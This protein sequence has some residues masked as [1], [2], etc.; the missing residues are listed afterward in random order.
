MYIVWNYHLDKPTEFDGIVLF[1]S[2]DDALQAMQDNGIDYIGT[3]LAGDCYIIEN[4]ENIIRGETVGERM[5]DYYG[6]V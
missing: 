1:A 6:H 5:R 2:Y 3:T 4:T